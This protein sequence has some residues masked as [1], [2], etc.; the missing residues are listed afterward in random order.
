MRGVAPLPELYDNRI[1]I[2]TS[3]QQTLS[4]PDRSAYPLSPPIP[5]A[6]QMKKAEKRK[7]EPQPER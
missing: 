3:I 7:A 2:S 5:S 1:Y 4:Y 6:V